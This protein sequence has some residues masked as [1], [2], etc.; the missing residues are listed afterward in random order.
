MII[1]N[2]FYRQ[3]LDEFA[4]PARHS[5]GNEGLFVIVNW[6]LSLIILAGAVLTAMIFA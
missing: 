3:F 1:V 2:Q 4:D 6:P 5:A